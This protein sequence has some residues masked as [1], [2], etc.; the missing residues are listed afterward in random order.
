VVN[1]FVANLG[2]TVAQTAIDPAMLEAF[3]RDHLNAT[4]P[5]TMA[6]LEPLRLR[7]ENYAELGFPAAGHTLRAK[8]FPADPDCREEWEIAFAPCIYIERADFREASN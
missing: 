5:R 4:A 2:L 1:K 7:L 8:H 6:V 3:C